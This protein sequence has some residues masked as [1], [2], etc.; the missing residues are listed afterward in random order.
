MPTRASFKLTGKM[1]PR[2]FCY[3]HASFTKMFQLISLTFVLINE[4]VLRVKI[5]IPP[6]TFVDLLFL[7]SAS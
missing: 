5:I 6:L 3:R 1:P 4:I 2:V 7:Q